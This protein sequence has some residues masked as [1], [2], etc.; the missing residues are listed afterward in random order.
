MIGGAL[1]VNG[2]PIKRERVEDRV[3]E[4]KCGAQ[5]VHVY[6]ETL[7]DGRAYLTQ[8]L[9]E[10]CKRYALGAKDDT[11]VFVV[12]PR[13]YFMMGDNRDDS[14]IAASPLAKA[15]A[16]YRRRIWS[17]ARACCSSPSMKPM[18]AGLPPGAGHLRSAGRGSET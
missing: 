9:S 2:A 4:T 18:R 15:W 13:H 10:T 5:P 6:R 3:E 1:N 8:K 17:A 14:A 16:M 7:P 12:P 11:D